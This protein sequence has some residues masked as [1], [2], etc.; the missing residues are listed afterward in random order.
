[1]VQVEQSAKLGTVWKETWVQMPA[2]PLNGEIDLSRAQMGT[3]DAAT[4]HTSA[5]RTTIGLP[6]EEGEE[7]AR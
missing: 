5:P 7:S 3:Q 4:S 2:Q 6:S 1:M